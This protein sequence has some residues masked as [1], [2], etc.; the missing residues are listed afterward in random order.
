MTRFVIWSRVEREGAGS[1]MAIAS[2]IPS[3][4]DAG[5]APEVRTR[6]CGCLDSAERA[7]AQLAR[8]LFDDIHAHPVRV[9]TDSPAE[10]ASAVY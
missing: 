7:A 6:R 8:E 1:F 9:S 10:R 4:P 3:I 2:A 5:R